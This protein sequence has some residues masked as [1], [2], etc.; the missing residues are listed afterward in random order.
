MGIDL[1]WR[2]GP[3][4]APIAGQ[5]GPDLGREAGIGAP[6]LAYAQG[7]SCARRGLP[8]PSLEVKQVLDCISVANAFEHAPERRRSRRSR[9]SSQSSSPQTPGLSPKPSPFSRRK[10]IYRVFCYLGRSFAGQLSMMIST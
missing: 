10:A 9:C 3:T 2:R 5:F 4:S 6:D 7:G 8:L 1:Y